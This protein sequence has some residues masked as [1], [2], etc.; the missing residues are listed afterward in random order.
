MKVKI[1]TYIDTVSSKELRIE[2]NIII[3]INQVLTVYHKFIVK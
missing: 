1:E 2:K 3:W